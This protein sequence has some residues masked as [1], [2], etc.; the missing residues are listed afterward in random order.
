MG[1]CFECVCRIVTRLRP[2]RCSGDSLTEEG[3]QVIGCHID[4]ATF[5]DV[6]H[7]L[8]YS[9]R[10]CEWIDH[11]WI[12]IE[13][14]KGTMT[15]DWQDLDRLPEV[16]PLRHDLRRVIERYTLDELIDKYKETRT[17]GPW[18]LARGYRG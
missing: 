5:I 9:H 7:G 1:K 4:D 17:Y 18:Y 12:E 16:R 13:T 15:I 14:S 2:D 6:C 11:G 8:V 10:Y 3:W